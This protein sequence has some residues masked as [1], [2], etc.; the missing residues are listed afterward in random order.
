MLMSDLFRNGSD[1]GAPG[2][3]VFRVCVCVC[4]V[5]FLPTSAPAHRHTRPRAGT[6]PKW[7]GSSTGRPG[8]A[9]RQ[10]AECHSPGAENT[11]MLCFRKHKKTQRL[12]V[13]DTHSP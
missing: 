7:R 1:D 5:F 9:G 2:N 10:R 3:C 13:K 12:Y 4:F 11:Q 6:S 8:A